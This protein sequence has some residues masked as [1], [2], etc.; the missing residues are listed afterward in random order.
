MVSAKSLNR[1]ITVSLKLVCGGSHN[2]DVT[3]WKMFMENFEVVLRG[4]SY[5]MEAL[6]KV[7]LYFL[8]ICEFPKFQE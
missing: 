8:N 1:A 3:Y 5:N 2:R 6:N 7:L 4:M